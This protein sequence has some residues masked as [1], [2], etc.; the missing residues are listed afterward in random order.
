[1]IHGY[2]LINTLKEGLLAFM[3]KHGFERIE[4]FRSHSLQFFTTHAE[5]VRR[6]AEVKAAG[7]AARA[8]MVT[9][10]TAWEGDRFVEQSDKLVAND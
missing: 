7:R 3:E 9:R 10:D 6:Q 8:G 2:Q 1:M 4:E 5:L